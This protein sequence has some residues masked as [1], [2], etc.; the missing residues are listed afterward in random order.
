MN[1]Y[2]LEEYWNLLDA[3]RQQE[4]HQVAHRS[5]KAYKFL[6][7]GADFIL[8]KLIQLPILEHC[9]A[10]QPATG[11]I[12]IAQIEILYQWIRSFEE[13]KAGPLHREAIDASTKRKHN[14][15]RLS[16]QIQNQKE[17]I[18][19]AKE[20]WRRSSYGQWNIMTK[21]E[22]D[23][24]DDVDSGRLEREL[25]KLLEQKKPRYKGVGPSVQRSQNGRDFSMVW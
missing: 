14:E 10:E 9:S 23:L 22:Q 2:T 5:F 17:T 11:D 1:E 4:A 24:V 12:A 21:Q 7:S 3:G 15:R 16:Q 18:A 13:H 6:L 8:H 25:K 19:Y 20:C